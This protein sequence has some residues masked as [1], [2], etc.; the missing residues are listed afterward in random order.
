M[1]MRVIDQFEVIEIN[2]HHTDRVLVA[3]CLGNEFSGKLH[4]AVSIMTASQ[5]VCGRQRK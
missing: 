1:P 3:P 5:L 2:Y 4:H